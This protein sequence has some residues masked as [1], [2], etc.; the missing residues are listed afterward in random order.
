MRARAKKLYLRALDYGLRSFEVDFPG[1]RD[2]LRADPDAALAKTTRKQV[3][4]LYYTAA[5]WGAAFALTKHDSDLSAD[6][7]LIEKLMQRALV[8][9]EGWEKGS[10]HE[11]FITWEG[12]RASVGGSLEK[13]K[14]HFERAKQLSGG[15]RVS[16][17]V[18]YAEV[19]SV[20]TQNK[21][22]FVALLNEALAVDISKAPDQKLANVIARRRA[23]WLLSRVDELFVE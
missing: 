13:A 15:Q 10:L 21:K 23:R 4:Q 18:T 6:Q 1:F 19:V 8:L 9:D 14:M 11:F 20:G 5:A 12:G 17:F 16:P 3:P 2:R 7:R 22:E